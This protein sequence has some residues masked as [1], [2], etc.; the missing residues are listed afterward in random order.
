MRDPHDSYV[1]MRTLIVNG[2]KRRLPQDMLEAAAA[3]VFQ[4]MAR[5]SP[6]LIHL[7]RSVFGGDR[8]YRERLPDEKNA[9]TT[10][11][12]HGAQVP[13]GLPLERLL[14]FDVWEGRELLCRFLGVD[15]PAD[16]PFPHLNGAR[17]LRE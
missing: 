3:A 9:V 13:E 12:R 11:E 2:P 1:S 7:S 15:V 17:S 10:F 5:L 16:E 8:I 6:V 14:V 4:S